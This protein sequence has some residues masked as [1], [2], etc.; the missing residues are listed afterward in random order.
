MQ[1]ARKL[2]GKRVQYFRKM[3]N[4]SQE[5]LSGRVGIEEKSLS[6]LERGVHFP[7]LETLER[8]QVELEVELKDFFEFSDKPSADELRSFLVTT[9]SQADY[10]TLVKLEKAVRKTIGTGTE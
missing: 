1:D 10:R 7:S 3:R 2:I 9:I 4:L 6:R 8:I 5:D